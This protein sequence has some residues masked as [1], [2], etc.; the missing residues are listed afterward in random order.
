MKKLYPLFLIFCFCFAHVP[1]LQGGIVRIKGKWSDERYAPTLSAHEHYDE[2]CSALFEKNYEVGLHHF[3]VIVYHFYDTPFYADALFYS[4][5]CFFHIKEYDLADKQFSLYLSLSS[6]T[7]HFEKVFEHKFLI[8]EA[9]RKGALKH[10]LGFKKL[11]RLAPGKDTALE[12]YDEVNIAMPGFEI[13]AKALYGKAKLLRKQKKYPESVEALKTLTRHFPKH[14][15]GAMGYVMISK[16]YLD[17]SILESQNPDFIPLAAINLEKLAQNYP[18][19]PKIAEVQQNLLSMKEIYAASLFQTGRFYEKK[20][21]PQA[22]AIYYLDAIHHYPGTQASQQ[23]QA[24][25]QKI[26]NLVEKWQQKQ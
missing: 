24:R 10:V 18:T 2:G 22:A 8:A 15:L 20:K 26:R 9:Y 7:R 1:S 4:G 17:Q 12:L 6:Q 3:L 11:P 13:A 14:P 23:C 25:Y 16:I 5:E 19:E 21:K